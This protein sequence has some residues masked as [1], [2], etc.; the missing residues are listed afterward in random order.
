MSV[1]ISGS[2]VYDH[3][4][5]FPDAF[6]NHIL[7]DQIH[8]LN[9]AFMIDKLEK[10][11]GGTAGNIAYNLKLLGG[12]PLIISTVG[13]DADSYLSH[14]KKNNIAT[15]LITTDEKRP[16]AS[17]F[18]TTDNEDNQIIA[19]YGGPLDST[20][21]IKVDP[22]NRPSLVLVSPTYK[23]VMKNHLKQ[24]KEQGL[25]VV[26]DPGQQLPAFSGDELKS[27]IALSDIVIGND[28]EMKLLQERTGYTAQNMLEHATMIITTLGERGS[29]IA[30]KD[31]VTE[32]AACPPLSVDDPTGAGDAYRAGFFFG[33]EKGLD[34]KTCGQIGSVAASFTIESYGT[35]NHTFSKEQFAERYKKTYAEEFEFDFK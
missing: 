12:E 20:P 11:W 25:T 5:N 1:L 34:L 14:F 17:A 35:Q 27:M 13:N 31:G 18:I 21:A 16:T 3:I 22:A 2:L 19:F 33:Y 6:K 28:Y 26:F 7:P 29:A 15:N 8:I 30:T 32:V 4:M 24:A 9:V 23:E 10:S